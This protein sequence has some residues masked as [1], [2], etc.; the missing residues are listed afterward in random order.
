MSQQQE[1]RGSPKLS[2]GSPNHILKTGGA[3][4]NTGGPPSS[5][6]V[7]PPRHITPTKG[8]Q[9]NKYSSFDQCGQMINPQTRQQFYNPHHYPQYPNQQQQFA[10]SGQSPGNKKIRHPIPQ[11][12]QKQIQHLQQQQLQQQQQQ[13][14]LQ[15]QMHQIK[16]QQQQQHLVERQRIAHKQQQEMRL[17]QQQQQQHLTQQQHMAPNNQHITPPN[18]AQHLAQSQQAVPSNQQL[19]TPIN[20]QAPHLPRHPKQFH[21]PIN[22]ASKHRSSSECSSNSSSR[23]DA[24]RTPGNA[25]PASTVSSGS[26]TDL[27]SELKSR[28]TRRSKGEEGKLADLPSHNQLPQNPSPRNVNQTSAGLPKNLPPNSFG[29]D[30]NVA[31][32]RIET[33]GTPTNDHK[34]VALPQKPSGLLRQSNGT[35][36]SNFCAVN[37][38]KADP[39]KADP[40][41]AGH[42]NMDFGSGRGSP[43]EE[44]FSFEAVLQRAKGLEAKSKPVPPPKPKINLT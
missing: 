28:Q 44:D 10:R 5:Q 7:M 30:Q 40:T 11:L 31:G 12:S 15:Q 42:L 32:P 8:T 20:Q 9:P 34:Y 43:A 33:P 2:R 24:D 35:T 22:E 36:S 19:A 21:S 41:K 23:Y 6:G 26:G 1:P 13:V 38:A 25:S 17:R 14:M 3:P 39:A 4:S 18:M 37:P 29:S 16:L 27:L